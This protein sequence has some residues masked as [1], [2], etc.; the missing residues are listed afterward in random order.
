MKTI[1]RFVVLAL[2]AAPVW[3]Q[4]TFHGNVART[5]VYD[6]PGPTR[7]GGV[8]WAFKTG[9]PIVTSPAIADGVVYIGEPRRP[10]PRG[11]SGDRQGE[12]EVQVEDADRVLA[13]GARRDAVL[14]LVDRR[15]RRARRRDRNAEVGV[16]RRVR[17][18]VR[19][20][21]PARLSVR[22]A[23]DPRRLGPLHLVAGGRERQGL[24][25]QRRR[26][27]LRRRRGDR[28]A[29]VEVP[30]RGTSC[31]PPP[32]SSNNVV[33]IG[34]WD[35]YL[36]AIDA[37]SGQEK[38]SFKAGEDP[39]IHNQVGFQSSP[40]VVD[41]TVYVGCRDAHVYALDAADRPQEVGLSDQQVVGD[42]HARGARRHGLRRDV[43]QRALHGARRQD[44]APAVQLRRQGVHLLLGR[45][46]PATWPT[47]ATTTASSTRST[48]RP[49]SWP[50]SSRPRPRSTIR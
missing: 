50:G 49:A 6:T 40:A 1:A 16:R 17:E 33:Y 30:D 21:E 3:A 2:A 42:R 41:G 5:G 32:P 39:A 34:S 12:V 19:G 36:Y 25:R 13:G 4:S 38:W 24:L 23:D 31:T 8:K 27:R 20:Q 18:E 11:R 43:G 28:R 37:E 14:R 15:A 45:R 7:L 35:S 10:P 29:A 44:R 22:G 26:E 48:R 9:G 46:W 47:S